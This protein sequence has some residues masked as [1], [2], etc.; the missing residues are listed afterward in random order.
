MGKAKKILV[1]V[2][3]LPFRSSPFIL[4]KKTH[5]G[6][7]FSWFFWLFS[8]RTS[9]GLRSGVSTT[10]QLTFGFIDGFTAYGQ[11]CGDIWQE[12][13][14]DEAQTTAD[15][16]AHETHFGHTLSISLQKKYTR[17]SQ[18]HPFDA[19]REAKE[20]QEP[21]PLWGSPLQ[22][23]PIRGFSGLFRSPQPPTP[24]DSAFIPHHR[25][26][27]LWFRHHLNRPDAVTLA[28]W[29]WLPATYRK[30]IT[31]TPNSPSGKGQRALNTPSQGS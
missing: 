21:C 14:G 12:L 30:S 26:S 29:S 19:S 13:S 4:Y 6:F 3:G 31:L 27:E 1:S 24:L 17:M 25:F 9:R 2:K 5:R 20:F 10:S 8:T 15:L 11:R 22:L 16:W 18:F 7:L 23:S 28:W